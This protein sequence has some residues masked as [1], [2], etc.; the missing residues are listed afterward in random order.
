MAYHL[1]KSREPQNV[2]SMKI[3]VEVEVKSKVGGSG[4]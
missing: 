2:L 4:I 1:N 3:K